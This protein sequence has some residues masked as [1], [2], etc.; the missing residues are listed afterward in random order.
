ME[1]EWPQAFG[2]T[3]ATP[4]TPSRTA[5]QGQG[6]RG[7]FDP[8]PF[9]AEP[10]RQRQSAAGVALYLT[11]DGAPRGRLLGRGEAA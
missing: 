7:G 9:T 11:Q 4:E 5:R 1:P 10:G 2:E 3:T 6:P 8:P